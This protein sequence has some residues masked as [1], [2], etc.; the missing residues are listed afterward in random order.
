MSE[1]YNEIIY[2]LLLYKLKIIKLSIQ[3]NLNLV[4][5]RQ[6]A[7]EFIQCKYICNNL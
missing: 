4:L 7:T 1:L 3:N 6:Y 5:S 2:N